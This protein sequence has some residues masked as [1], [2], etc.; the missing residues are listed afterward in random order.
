LLT[1]GVLFV[2]HFFGVI[3]EAGPPEARGGLHTRQFGNGYVVHDSTVSFAE[4]RG[5]LAIVCGSPRFE[6]RDGRAAGGA[7]S[8]AAWLEL[9]DQ[10]GSRALER[11]RGRF[12][13][14]TVRPADGV[15]ELATDRFGTWP[16]CYAASSNVFAFADRVTAMPGGE[17]AVSRQALFH[18]LYF[19]AIPGPMTVREGVTRAQPGHVVKFHA[20]R[21]E[22]SR[23]W[24]PLFEERTRP[25]FEDSRDEFVAL[26]E[27]AVA[28]ECT[29]PRMGAFLSGGTDSS[30]VAGM[31]GKV[32]GAA[33]QTYSIGFDAG[34][35]DEMAYAR[36]AARHFGTA[37]H[38]YYVT[39][40]DVLRAMPRVATHYEQPFGNSSAVPAF[41]CARRAAEDGVA[42]LLAGDGGDELFG[43]NSRYAKHRVFDLYE[44][45]PAVARSSLLE[46]VF[47]RP[48]WTHVPVFKKLAS[49]IDQ[50]RIPMPDRTQTYNLLD[51]VTPRAVLEDDFLAAVDAELPQQQQRETWRRVRATANINRELAFDWKYTLTDNDLQKVIGTAELAGIEVGFPL[52]ADELVDFSLK[53]PPSWKLRG[54]ALRWFF[55]KALEQFLPPEI[56]V[57]K[58]HG[59]GL[60]FGV[61]VCQHGGLMSLARATLLSL[62][63][64]RIVRAAYI[65][66][67]LERQ[68]PSHPGYY[69]E[70][71][72]ILMMM[73]LWLQQNVAKT[74]IWQ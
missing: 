31:L 39:P 32:T 48:M 60:P 18:Y 42:K 45:V 67:L 71:V 66:E 69:G 13:A 2:A 23:Y 43:G 28:R 46:P 33:A 50:A 58:K 37:H 41:I 63:E 16:I 55:K 65:E 25:R 29:A 73:E 3:G 51:R 12:C 70:M 35:Y 64:R 20:G 6:A 19:H 17:R 49:Y 57:K 54:F 44:T 61:W 5:A 4:R 68:L 7:D 74:R 62:S 15:V 53:L 36:I 72:W 21:V 52:L 1:A 56:I 24:D 40:D 47:L 59:F 27:Q 9:L 8:A 10:Y 22:T 38:E 34:G 11:V 26:I 14:V 30:T